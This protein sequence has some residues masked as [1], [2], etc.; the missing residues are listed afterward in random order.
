[1]R[2]E[3]IKP[4]LQQTGYFVGYNELDPKELKALNGELKPP[5]IFFLL[6]SSN[7]IFADS[8]VYMQIARLRVELY[9]GKKDFV[10]ERKL[11]QILKGAGICW[12]KSEFFIK[13]E[14]LYQITYESELILSD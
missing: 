3:D 1:M 6:P 8:E 4:L 9:T 7:N 10:A 11:E 13:P 12:Q 5:Y 14:H 2:A